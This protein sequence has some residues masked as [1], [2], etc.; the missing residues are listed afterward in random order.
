[1]QRRQ[2]MAP[3]TVNFDIKCGSPEKDNAM[4]EDIS[5][6]ST[7]NPASP[8]PCPI[9][10]CSNEMSFLSPGSSPSKFNIEN[11]NVQLPR[12]ISH[13]STS[14]DSGYC[15]S[16]SNNKLGTSVSSSFKFIEP[17]RPSMSSPSTMNNKTPSK[18]ALSSSMNTSGQ[19]F[20]MLSTGSSTCDATEDEFMDLMDMESLEE[21]SQMPSD[22]SS[23]ICKDIKSTS[24]T[25]ENKRFLETSARKCLNMN[26]GVKSSLFH[27]PST[28]K[29]ST[30]TSSLITT[31]ERQCLTNLSGNITPLRSFT[32]GAFK[33]PE[34]PV[35]S[36]V[37]P[38]R[39]KCEN[40]PPKVESSCLI[41]EMP[42]KR[43]I[44]RKSMSMNDA[45][46][47]EA[48]SRS[49]SETNL[50]GDFT[51]EHVLP[52]IEGKHN[53]LKSISADT[54]KR[55]LDGEFD[56]LVSSFKV[57]DCR[58]PYE[59]QGGHIA[60]AVNLYTHDQILEELMKN[61]SENN[62]NDK[63]DILVFHCEFSSERGPK[64]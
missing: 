16:L 9:S 3:H 18:F 13:D 53:D 31:P 26:N 28:P 61:P 44:Y 62:D 47:N 54:M 63:R 8:R 12:T 29:T 4:S 24:K 2:N 15:G 5:F 46:I 30:L 40:D 22:L 50:I 1:M 39:M 27:S 23:L 33:R 59:F 45:V 11:T 34:R 60:G 14:M 57:I 6:Y 20:R 42:P 49:S 10:P 19:G 56:E 21:E 48:L 7:N 38:K 55:L 35:S 25:P 37:Q 36:P 17:K 41:K 52:L 58:Y 64:L 32:T 51:R 43:P